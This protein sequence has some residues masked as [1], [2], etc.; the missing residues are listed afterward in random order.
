MKLIKTEGEYEQALKRIENL[1]LQNELDESKDSDELEIL[2]ML[3]N[4]YEEKN[5]IIE[6][7]SAIDAIMFR[8]EQLNLKQI[9]MIEYFGSKSKAS[10]VLSGKRSL[11]LPMIKKLHKGLGI[12]AEILIQ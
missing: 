1:M 7:P 4:H 11:S 10:E 3:V 12:S 6:K 5:I 9:D 8:M 2:I